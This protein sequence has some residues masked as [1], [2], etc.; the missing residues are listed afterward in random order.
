MGKPMLVG[1]GES[2][3]A[4]DPGTRVWL[5]AERGELQVDPSRERLAAAERDIGERRQRD[6]AEQA[7]ARSPAVTADAVRIGVLANVGSAAEAAAAVSAGAE[8]CGLLRTEFLFLDRQTP[9]DVASQAQEYQ[10]VVDGFAG[11]PVVIRTLDAG[12]DK[13]LAFLPQPHEDNPALG[14]RGIRVGLRHPELLATQLEALLSVR[15]LAACRVL[16]PMVNEVSEMRRVREMIDA[17][18]ARLGVERPALGAMI[19]TPAAAL[20]AGQICEVADFISI[21]TNDL[22]QYTLAMDRTHPELAA[23]LDG[24]HPAVLRLIASAAEGARARGREVAVCG[25][26]AADPLAVPVL[27]GLGVQE[28]SVVPGLIPRTKARIRELTLAGCRALASRVL[29]LESAAAV[30]ALLRDAERTAQS[31]SSTVRA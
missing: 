10:R 31:Q 2:I 20:S 23:R 6:A 18:A 9:P 7:A 12:A 5:D 3:L 27:L 13:P 17:L 21:G 26:L 15:P 25:G 22:T 1:L 28:L 19:E 14:V 11:L 4:I 24:L 16:L 8:G 29:E 30:R